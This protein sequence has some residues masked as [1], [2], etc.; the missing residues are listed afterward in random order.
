MMQLS[1]DQGFWNRL[2]QMAKRTFWI[3]LGLLLIA[4]PV[5]SIFVWDHGWRNV[6]GA[7]GNV[8]FWSALLAVIAWI[9]AR[10][11]FWWLKGSIRWGI[12]APKVRKAHLL[13]LFD[14][15][16]DTARFHNLHLIRVLHVYQVGRRGTKC[17]VEH[18]G[19][20]RQDAW[21]W[22]FNPKRGCVFMVRSTNAYGPHNS[23][24]HVMYI[25]SQ[26]TGAGVVGGVPAA[27]WK[28]AHKRMGQQP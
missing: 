22:N 13:S 9:T 17:V 7:M 18:P 6:M 20:V 21:F 23:N 26:I 15:A 19:G 12:F 27:A 1:L 25:G 28:A 24:A 3:S 5:I 4:K 2:H 16:I 11:A 8:A 14:E 10:V